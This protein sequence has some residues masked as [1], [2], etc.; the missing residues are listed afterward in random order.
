MALPTQKR[1]S[2]TPNE[3]SFIATSEY[4]IDV[5]PNFSMGQIR[6]LSVRNKVQ[7]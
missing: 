1:L 4:I 7:C 3:L 6:L 2:L 5:V